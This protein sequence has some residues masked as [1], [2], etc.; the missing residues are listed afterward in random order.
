[1][2][3]RKKKHTFSKEI[4]I[5]CQLCQRA[6]EGSAGLLIHPHKSITKERSVDS[7]LEMFN[8]TLPIGK[9][10][11][12]DMSRVLTE[13]QKDPQSKKKKNLPLQSQQGEHFFH[14]VEI[15]EQRLK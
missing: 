12:K 3:V 2:K 6:L 1:M 13:H 5:K 15:K 14:L 10:M 7:V 11:T 4:G 9:K 8:K